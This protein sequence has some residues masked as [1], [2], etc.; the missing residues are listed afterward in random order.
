MRWLQLKAR[1]E[2]MVRPRSARLLAR[3]VSASLLAAGFALL[4][5]VSATAHAEEASADVQACASAYEQA[6]VTR[7]DG[8][9]VEAQEHLRI[10]VQD[11]CPDFVKSDCGQWLS[12]IKR[13]I[14]SVIFSPVDSNGQELLDVKVSVDGKDV[15]LDGR[16]VELDPGQH[17]ITYEYQGVTKTEKVAIRQGEKNRVI[18]LEVAPAQKDT[19]ADGVLDAEDQCP[20]E[21]GPAPEGCPKAEPAATPAQPDKSL[22]LGAYVG[23]GVGGVGLITFAVVGTM[24]NNADKAAREE[25]LSGTPCTQARKEELID[26]VDT[27]GLIA[28]IGLGV[29]IA[30]AATGTVLFILSMP[31]DNASAAPSSA[32]HLGVRPTAGGSTLSLSG[33]F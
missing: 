9:L 1:F 16:A 18:K 6:Q 30:G 21:A 32:L 7:N 33:A 29:G 4:Q 13:D 8:R 26:D 27:K 12:D 5:L 3:P 17:E 31:K 19:D 24:A 14:P 22:R 15:T 11:H 23:W 20:T 2:A 10:C 25:C 28:N